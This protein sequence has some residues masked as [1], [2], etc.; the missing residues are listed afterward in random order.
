MQTLTLNRPDRLNAL[1]GP[2]KLALLG[3]LLAVQPE[4]AAVVIRGAGRAFCAGQDIHTAESESR[5]ELYL[6]LQELTRAIRSCP[7][8][9]IACVHGH[10]VGGGV[11]L[12]LACD[13]VVADET[14]QFLFP[15]T[16]LGVS[17]TGGMSHIL[18]SL[19][20]H[21]RAKQIVLL[22]EPVCAA[23]ALEYGLVNAVARSGELDEALNQI[24][25]RLLS[26][27]QSAVRIA[28]ELFN[29]SNED[30]VAGSLDREVYAARWRVGRA[31]ASE[32]A[33]HL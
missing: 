22:G 19:V 18:P 6:Q 16:R 10:L 28:K 26:R 31:L 5:P 3:A 4:T 1:S 9:V 32:K 20:G 30:G 33:D 21:L 17:V 7:C 25:E 24:L 2:L 14:A 11:E 15:E 29:A 12:A 13:L 8:P 23:A 27:D